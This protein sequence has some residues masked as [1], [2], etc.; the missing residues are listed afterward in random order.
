M[1]ESDG[2][3]HRQLAVARNNAELAEQRLIDATP[4]RESVA[5]LERAISGDAGWRRFTALGE[6]EFTAEGMRQMRAICRLMALSN[7][8]IKRGLNLRSAYV[9]GQGVEIT[10]RAN[11]S[12]DSQQDVQA[13]ITA[14]LNDGQ[15]RD[16]VT[17][18][19]ARDQLEHALGTDG[20]V[21]IVLFT[22]PMS[23]WVQARTVIADEIAEIIANPDDRTETWYYRRRWTETTYTNEG[24]PVLVQ[25]EKLYPS[26]DYRP[27]VRPKRFAGVDID[28]FAPMVQVAVNRPLGWQRGVPDAY[29]AVNWARAYKEFLENW[30][31][32]VKSLSR[33]AWRLTAKGSTERQARTRL[34]TPPPVDPTG[35]ALD[36]GATAITP[37][38]AQLEAIPKSGATIDAESGRPLAMMVSSA[39]DV[40][41][42]MLLSDPGQT[43]A[44]ATAETLDQPT[45]LAMGQRRE[46]WT[47]V[48]LRILRYVIAE[49]VRAPQGVL[50]G[51]VKRD[52]ITGRE[53]VKLAG[54]TDDTIDI[55]WPDLDD[56]DPFKAV[57]AIKLAS[58]TGTVPPEQIA[59]LL[60]TALG[61]RDVDG[62]MRALVDDDGQF[63]WPRGPD[64]GDGARALSAARRGSDPAGAGIGSMAP[65]DNDE[66]G[67]DDELDDV[68]PLEES[69][70]PITLTEAEN[71][72]RRYWLHGPGLAK[73]ATKP[74]PWTALYQHLRKH[75]GSARA[76]RI[77]SQWFKDHFGYWPGH[78]K[79]ANK[80]GPG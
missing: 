80:T 61:V 22:R 13:V 26:V 25:R 18:P 46:L 40:P 55:T 78:R 66:D 3:L 76:K 50:Q 49:S 58:D 6:Q 72:L 35:R 62:I 16:S 65:D 44:R 14:F 41:V 15:N 51:T 54:D 32:L 24:V 33:F 20:D 8:L 63:V 73:W 23:G 7:P 9:W 71:N 56:I 59:R 10:A 28:W 17:G 34:A 69:A 79:G 70:E 38:D 39:L 43:G 5:D 42:T 45:E 12:R 30:A 68:E 29:A 75:V 67:P 4:L 77:A 64:V 47:Q 60:L 57:E 19:A 37:M 27:T 1:A 52:P 31:T 36:V 74:H 2:G 48:M 53:V 21:F 11:G